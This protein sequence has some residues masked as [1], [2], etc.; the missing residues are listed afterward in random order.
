[1]GWEKRGN[2]TYYYR[3][4][5]EGS[6]VRSLYVG[7]GQTAA[8]IAQLEMMRREKR[9]EKR[10]TYLRQVSE[11]QAQDAIVE[12]ACRMIDGVLEAAL[13]VAGFHTHKRQW[14]KMR[15]YD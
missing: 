11:F 15:S 9:A 1:M 7:G 2:G 3:K 6:R 4:E 10:N 5:R 12:A 13:I 8:L 14:R